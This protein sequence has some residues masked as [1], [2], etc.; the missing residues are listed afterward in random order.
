MLFLNTWIHEFM[1]TYFHLENCWIQKF[2]TL[3]KI[4]NNNLKEKEKRDYK[5]IK[6]FNHLHQYT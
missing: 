4:R 6:V 2:G 3:L 5:V 1:T